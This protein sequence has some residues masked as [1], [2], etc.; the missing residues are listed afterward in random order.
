MN[1]GAIAFKLNC[2]LTLSDLDR[3][4]R[5]LAS[6]GVRLE[7]SSWELVDGQIYLEGE[8]PKTRSKLSRIEK[9]CMRTGGVEIDYDTME[10]WY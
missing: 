5:N 4:W 3:I 10:D 9:Y 1:Y 2:R 7:T 8:Y 6:L